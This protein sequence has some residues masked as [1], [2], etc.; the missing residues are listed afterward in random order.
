MF[1]LLSKPSVKVLASHVAL[2]WICFTAADLCLGAESER[3]ARL[4]PTVP[5]EYTEIPFVENAAEPE[6]TAAEQ[7]RGYMLFHRPITEPVYANTRPLAHER[8]KTLSAFATPGE[9]EPLTLS[10]FPLRELKNMKVRVSALEGPAGEI[11]TSEITIRLAT[12]WNMGYPRYTS[13][14]TYRR[15][16]ELLERVT[17]HSSPARECQ[18]WW[19]RIHVPADAKSGLYRAM[20]TVRD[21]GFQDAVE[22]PVTL[23]VLGFKLKSDPAKHY[24]AYYYTRNSVV[25]RGKDEPFI[26][27]ATG[28]DYRAMVEYGIDTIPTF[29]LQTDKSGEKIVLRDAT[30]LDRMIAAG[31]K[32]PVPVTAGSVIGRIYRDTTPDGRN[33]GHWTISKMPPPEFYDKVTSLFKAFEAERRGKGWPVFVCCPIDEVAASHKEFGWRVYRAV[34]AAGVRTYATKNPAGADAA[35]YRP[36][37]DVWCSQPY[38]AP[39]EKIIAQNRYEYWCYPNHNAGEIK[40]RRVMCKG[41]R[42]TYGF[43]FW[44]SGYTTLIPWNW[45]WTPGTDQFDYLRGRRS[46]CGQRIGDDGQVI[47]AVYWECFREGRDDARYIYTLQQA[48]WEREGSGN[49]TC[50]RRVADAKAIL[51]ETWDAISVQQKYLADGMWPSQ[52]FDARRWRLAKAIDALLQYPPVRSG[53]APSVLVADTL[54]KDAL[55]KAAGAKVPIIEQAT[56]EGNMESKDLGG[57]FSAW[58]NGTKEGVAEVTTDAGTGGKKG[59]RWRVSIDHKTDGGEGG[60]YPV[61]WPRI[62]RSFNKDEL[63]MSLYDYLEFLVRVDSDRDEV[64]DDSTLLGLSIRTHENTSRLFQTKRD[65]GG[66]Q[67]TWIPV[68]FSLKEIMSAAGVGPAP[69]KTISQVQIYLCE[70]DFQHGANLSF[71]VAKARLLRFKSPIISQLDAPRFVMLSE[72]KLQ[73]GFEVMGTGS[74]TAGSH[75]VKASVT[76]S[77][78]RTLAE[79]SQDLTAPRLLVLD[80]SRLTPGRWRVDVEVTTA[81]GERCSTSSCEFEGL[82]GP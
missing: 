62:A 12:Y 37:I 20:V 4:Q 74:V 41:G 19:L 10:I 58:R 73:I 67:K 21:D 38:S 27:M 39:Y 80:L 26:R 54:P 45:N 42:M 60:Q 76:D 81:K 32:G 18:R 51:Q 69:W 29:A 77:Q 36:Y 40:D 50:Q 17:A 35:V 16:P 49:T 28:N 70:D 22:I 71:D 63:D 82:A 7:Q 15:L 8:L 1:Y 31:M 52:E 23:Q 6:F 46:G 55:L 57:G 9:F 65:L 64:A 2:T 48:L 43:G 11:P 34:R 79:T 56:A 13:R 33:K 30:E 72:P 24:S 75:C 44:R 68:R 25:F 61:G 47:P 59:L 78:G 66:Q 53:S 14:K 5:A 3:F